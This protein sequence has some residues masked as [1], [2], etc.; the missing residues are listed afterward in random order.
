MQVSNFSVKILSP[1]TSLDGPVVWS[2]S[3]N[4]GDVGLIPAGVQPQQDPG[5]P[6]G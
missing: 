2:L 1:G 4:A 6:S 3:Y 5:E